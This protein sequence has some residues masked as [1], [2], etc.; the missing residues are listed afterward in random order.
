MRSNLAE[1]SRRSGFP[2]RAWRHRGDDRRP[3][4]LRFGN[5]SAL[6]DV[7]MCKAEPEDRLLIQH[8]VPVTGGVSGS[9]LIDASGKVIGIVNGGNTVTV[10]K[11]ADKGAGETAGT[12]RRRTTRGRARTS[13]SRAPR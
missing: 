3:S 8:S 10:R 6:T 4:A 11:V 12:T 2:S 5:I 7:F 9:P 13:A 1:P